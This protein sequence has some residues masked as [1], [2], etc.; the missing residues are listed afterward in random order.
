MSGST[1]LRAAL[2]RPRAPILCLTPLGSTARR[3]CL[4]WGVNAVISPDAIDFGD[5]IDK[6]TAMAVD[7]E[8][9][10]AGDEVRSEEHT[11]ELQSLMRSSYAVFCLKQQNKYTTYHQTPICIK[12]E[13]IRLKKR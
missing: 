13:E 5:M 1:A 8:L 11:S 7:R 3:L 6:A 2:E 9:A 4:A 12:S 10:K